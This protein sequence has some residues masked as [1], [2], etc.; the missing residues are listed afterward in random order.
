MLTINLTELLEK[1]YEAAVKIHS[2]QVLSLASDARSVTLQVELTVF[3]ETPSRT[4][5]EVVI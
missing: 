1:Q 4:Y 2:L 5:V 3:A